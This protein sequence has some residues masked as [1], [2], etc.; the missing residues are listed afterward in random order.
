MQVPCLKV[1][2]QG[3]CPLENPMVSLIRTHP[4][5]RYLGRCSVGLLLR[6]VLQRI[7]LDFQ[8]DP[9]VRV[10][11]VT[12]CLAGKPRAWL[13][14]VCLAAPDG[15]HLVPWDAAFCQVCLDG[16]GAVLRQPLVV[17]DGAQTVG[18]AVDGDGF[19]LA[20]VLELLDRSF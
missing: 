10:Q 18:V 17:W 2:L 1:P 5:D 14:L 15:L 4:I 13:D 8:H 6:D 19:E 7:P 9:A 11:A 3:E 16:V 12:Q 20:D